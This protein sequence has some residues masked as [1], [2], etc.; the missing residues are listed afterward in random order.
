MSSADRG[1]LFLD[2]MTRLGEAASYETVE[3]ETQWST[4]FE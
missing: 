4:E 3:A 1:E 2:I